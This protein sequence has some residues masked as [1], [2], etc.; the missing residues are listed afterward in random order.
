MNHL[1][2]ERIKKLTV[3]EDESI[4]A[5]MRAI[6]KGTLGIAFVVNAGGKFT[7]LVTDGDVRRAI[8][9]GANIESP[10][11]EI[12]NTQPIVIKDKPTEEQLLALTR[13]EPIK[14]QLAVGYT[15]KIPV[16]DSKSRVKDILMLYHSGK[17]P[18]L[19]SQTGP[20]ALKA[21]KKVLIIGCAG[22]LG[23]V[24]TRE[25]IAKGYIVNGL[26]NLTYG[27]HGIK[28]LYGKKEF[29]FIQG[30]IRDIKVL[31][32]SI[33]DCDAVIHLAAIVGDPACQLDAEETISI[34]YLATKMITEVCKYNQINTFLFASTCSVY[35]E[36]ET[37]GVNATEEA[38][39][40]P[41]SL[42]AE[43]KIKSEKAILEA[44]DENFSPTILRMATL[45]GLSPRMRLDLVV[46]L[47]TA[48]ATTEGVIT[49]FGGNQWRPLLHVDDAAE[50]YI[51]CLEAPIEK[52]RGQIFNTGSNQQ[53]CTISELGSILHGVIPN[54]QIETRDELTDARNY[55]VAFDKISNILSYRTEKTIQDGILEIKHAF[56]EG[57]IGDYTD[58]K[59]SNY[60]SLSEEQRQMK[61]AYA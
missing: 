23:S 51:R 6:D 30:D 15:L 48:R 57:I 17:K 31:T 53:N 58:K 8:L 47:L 22:Y 40:N 2:D 54:L 16:L 33:K 7:G 34:N 59:F 38:A 37:P 55:S 50:A 14:S 18:A 46:N 56:D 5:A 28:E 45:Y 36:S 25:L 32:Q 35:G 13:R 3:D 19:L 4:K 26:D 42:Y 20:I 9:Q 29:R 41:V 24:L 44:M 10:V 61:T 52:I 60:E 39:L 21:I 43:M 12:T 11:K 1:Q 27:D 49:I